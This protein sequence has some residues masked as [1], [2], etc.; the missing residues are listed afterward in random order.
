MKIFLTKDKN[1]SLKLIKFAGSKMK[2]TNF[3]IKY[4]MGQ[5]KNLEKEKEEPLSLS[6]PPITRGEVKYIFHRAT[7]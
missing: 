7:A 6:T 2:T 3:D 4:K 5:I 1:I